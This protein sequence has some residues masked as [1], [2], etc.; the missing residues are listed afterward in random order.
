SPCARIANPVLVSDSLILSAVPGPPDK[1]KLKSTLLVLPEVQSGPP[2]ALV[3]VTLPVPV[4]SALTLYVPASVN[5]HGPRPS[6]MAT[7]PRRHPLASLLRAHEP[8]IGQTEPP[9]PMI[10]SAYLPLKLSRENPL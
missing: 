10:P 4:P 3:T 6:L 2:T 9:V 5:T 7:V 1:T 8:A